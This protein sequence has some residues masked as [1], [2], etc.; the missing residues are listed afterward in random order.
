MRIEN[1]V[2][3]EGE[4]LVDSRILIK[5]YNNL[6]YVYIILCTLYSIADGLRVDTY[7]FF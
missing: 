6:G 2:Y 3:L 7:I 1:W 4:N 5:I